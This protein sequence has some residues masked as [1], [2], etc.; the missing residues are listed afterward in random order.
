MKNTI[1]AL[2]A[3]LLATST[4]RADDAAGTS[5]WE[6]WKADLR[7]TWN[8]RE[9][10]I[11][12]PFN[13]YHVRGTYDNDRLKQFNEMPW[14]LGVERHYTDELRNRHSLYV[15]VFSESYSKPQPAVGYAWEKN[16]F[17][18]NT[19]TARVGLGFNAMLTGRYKSNYF[20][21]PGATPTF[22]V[23]YRCYSVQTTWVPYLG[24]NDGNVFLTMFKVSI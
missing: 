18:N 19:R 1:P 8:S 21:L 6:S 10:A 23:N 12:I 16:I 7:A 15:L 3:L 24:R 14:G 2:C 20:P 22:S 11:M 9:H 4:L 5:W 17:L 13:T